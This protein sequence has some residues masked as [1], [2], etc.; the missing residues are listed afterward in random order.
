MAKKSAA[1]SPKPAT[2]KGPNIV[3][4]PPAPSG[5]EKT[6]KQETPLNL[7]GPRPNGLLGDMGP[8]LGGFPC[9][10]NDGIFGYGSPGEGQFYNGWNSIGLNG[11]GVPYGSWSNYW[12]MDRNPTVALS[13][14]TADAPIWG[15]KLTYESKPG[16]PQEV[17]DF[18]RSQVGP[19]ERHILREYCRSRSDGFHVEE[20]V[21]V[22]ADVTTMVEDGDTTTNKMF[23][24]KKL[25]PLAP[26]LTEA[27]TDEH[28]DLQAVINQ[29]V[30]LTDSRRFFWLAYDGRGINLYGRSRKEN[31]KKAWINNEFL[32]DIIPYATNITV[33]PFGWV[34]YPY[35]PPGTVD[36]A[37]NVIDN[38]RGNAIQIGKALEA[39]RFAIIPDPNAPFYEQMYEKGI[40]PSK[41]MPYKIGWNDTKTDHGQ[42]FERLMKLSDIGIVSGTLMPPQSIL[43]AKHGSQATS[44]NHSDTGVKV[45]EML[46]AMICQGL[47]VAMIDTLLV[48]NYGEKYRGAVWVKPAPLVDMQMQFNNDLVKQT[49]NGPMG[50]FLLKRVVNIA[51]ILEKSGVK[52]NEFDQADLV[53]DMEK[54]A[55]EQRKVEIQMAAAVAGAK[56][57]DDKPIKASMEDSGGHW[58]TMDGAHVFIGKGDMIEKGPSGMVGKK[59]GELKKKGKTITENHGKNHPVTKNKNG[60]ETGHTT[61]KDENKKKDKR[62]PRPSAKSILAKQH[63]RYVDAAIQRYSEEHNEPVLAMMVGGVSMPDGEPADVVIPAN[64]KQ[65]IGWRESAAKYRAAKDAGGKPSAFHVDGARSH[66]VELKTMTDNKGGKVYMHQSAID[67]KAVFV[68]EHHAHMHTVVFD[69]Q[70]V[71]NANGEGKHDDSQRRIFYK[72]GWGRS[73][74]VNAMHEVKDPS[75]LRTLINTPTHKLPDAA[76]PLASY[77]GKK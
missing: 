7:L 22:V 50:P 37:G 58:V 13:A 74:G 45:N 41:C 17:V 55:A 24:L 53:E 48:Q 3:N 57:K 68:K 12:L 70:K 11:Y 32:Y 34:S 2:P 18:I 5:G 16:V 21:Y 10:I 65:L 29:G 33:K 52:M 25:K 49:L 47:S 62:E 63:S 35:Y 59:P 27:V 60:P 73:L 71:F 77:N 54:E 14:A 26:E 28:G 15:V 20:V 51:N 23:T 56:G 36:Q 39:G 66:G 31:F 19:W 61:T 8:L 69:D 44:E 4:A 46:L 67:R 43:E 1:K 9:T 38:L 6:L 75:E 76:K 64:E 42:G 40:D 30:K 72:R